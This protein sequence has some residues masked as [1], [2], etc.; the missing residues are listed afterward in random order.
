MILG[1]M[2]IRLYRINQSGFLEAGYEIKL[3]LK[4]VLANR[5]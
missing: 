2:H 4:T 1:R 3:G 5:G